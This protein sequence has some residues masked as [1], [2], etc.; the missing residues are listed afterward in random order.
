MPNNRVIY[1]WLGVG[2]GINR[3]M[4]SYEQV[5]GKYHKNRWK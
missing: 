4:N 3:L 2:K 1:E 5:D